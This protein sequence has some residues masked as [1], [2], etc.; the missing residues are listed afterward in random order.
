MTQKCVGV[1][2]K[3]VGWRR[4]DGSITSSFGDAPWGGASVR[5]A[6]ASGTPGS[7][8]GAVSSTSPGSVRLLA[9]FGF[10]LRGFVLDGRKPVNPGHGA[11]RPTGR[12]V[13]LAGR[14][15][16]FL[17]ALRSGD[18]RGF[19]RVLG[20]FGFSGNSG[21]IGIEGRLRAIIERR[22]CLGRGVVQPS[23]L[24]GGRNK[25]KRMQHRRGC[26]IGAR[27]QRSVNLCSLTSPS[28][29]PCDRGNPCPR[30]PPAGGTSS[31]S[32]IRPAIA[33]SIA[34]IARSSAPLRLSP[35]VAASGRSGHGCQDSAAVVLQSDRLTRATSPRPTY[36]A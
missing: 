5:V 19:L 9:S 2:Q 29:G 18:A 30:R 13:Y 31:R 27:H 4:G 20:W 10:P 15:I 7:F 14:G 28:A 34:S 36:G 6:V 23:S 1:T 32:A 11:R 12:R 33:V 21:S 17:R 24:T 25:C 26:A 8:H 22:P 35:K 16:G 3:C